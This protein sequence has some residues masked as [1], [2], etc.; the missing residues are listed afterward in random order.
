MLSK[1][2]LLVCV[3]CLVLSACSV[4]EIAAVN[5]QISD[6]PSGNR[7]QNHSAERN[8][9]EQQSVFKLIIP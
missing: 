9:P 1:K 8:T 6:T 7:I 5:K 4:D 3:S 2:L